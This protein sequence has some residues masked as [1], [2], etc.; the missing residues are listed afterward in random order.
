M[1]IDDEIL[2]VSLYVI[3]LLVTRSSEELI[4]TFK[5][6]MTDVFEMTNLGQMT[7]FLGMEV[8]RK[9]NENFDSQ[10]NYAKEVLIKFNIEGRKQ[11]ANPINQREKFCNE[12]GAKKIDERLYRSLIGCLMYLFGTRSDIM[13]AMSLLSRYMH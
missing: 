9:Q 3:D 2:V 10:Q 8:Q 12:D 6:E 11:T 5:V 4:N 1:K 13:Y 7:F